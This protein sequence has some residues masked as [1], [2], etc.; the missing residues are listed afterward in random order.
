MDSSQPRYRIRPMTL[1]DIDQVLIMDRLSFPLPWPARTYEHEI[2]NSRNSTMLVVEKMDE[3]A[4][5]GD[6]HQRLRRGLFR[7]FRRPPPRPSSPMLVGYAGFWCL[8]DEVHISTIAVHPDWRGRK[9]GEMLLWVMMR[10]AIR[11]EA[12]T[13]TLE[14]R[15]SNEVAQN[16]YRKYGFETVGRRRGYY[17]DNGEDAYMMSVSPLDENYKARLAHY[18]KELARHLDITIAELTPER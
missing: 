1:E 9:L 17:R 8:S 3:P 14:V 11:R 6:N 15:V 10:E 4:P 16:L 5:A 13:V 2:Q 7:P 12:S 18:G